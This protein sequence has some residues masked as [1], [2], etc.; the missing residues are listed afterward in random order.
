MR[1]S[2]GLLV[3]VASGAFAQR[4]TNSSTSALESSTTLPSN[5]DTTTGAAPSS[6]TSPAASQSVDLSDADL[7]QGTSLVTGANGQPAVRMAAGANGVAEF[8]SSP[9]ITELETGSQI[10][11]RFDISV[12][13]VVESRKRDF[14]GCTLD[15]KLDGE[16][17][18]S[19]PLADTN[20]ASVEQAS[21]PT[22]LN[23]DK[24]DIQFLQS[25]GSEPVQLDVSN[26]AVAAATD[27]G[28][29]GLPTGAATET[30]TETGTEVA[31]GTNS[32][33]ATTNSEGETVIPTGT[34]TG[35]AI[36]TGTN[37]EG[38]TTNSEGETVIPTGSET[39]I[40]TNSAGFTTNSE[41]ET[42]FPTGTQT[43]S[44]IAT[45]T[46][47][48]GATTNSEGETV[49]P[50]GTATGT[51]ASASASATSPAGFPGSVGVFTLFGCVGSSAGFPTFELAETN[52]QM[53]LERC[54]SLCTGRAYF[55]VYDT[56]CYCGDEIDADNTSRV[57]IDQCDIE[58]PGDKDNF[59]GGDGRLNRLRAR[60]AV[61]AGRLL[62]VY[63]SA[64]GAGATVTDSVTQ[65]VTDETTITTTF[66]TAITGAETTTT[67]TVTA[68]QI[69]VNGKCYSQGSDRTVF[70]F[71]EVNGSDCDNEW[72]Y[73][74]EECSCQGGKQYV[75]KFCSGG[76]CAG[77][78]VY[79]TQEC[80][81]WWNHETFFVAADC[82]CKEETVIYKPWENS[83]GTPNN[84]KA[85]LVPVCS[86]PK[87]PVVKV[88]THGGYTHPF[89][90]GTWTNG[91]AHCSGPHCP[92]PVP[93]CSG[94]KCP[95]PHCSGPHCPSPVPQCSG[96]KCPAPH[97]SGPHCPSPAPVCSGP[98]CPST[99]VVTLVP[100][101]SGA[102]C[103]AKPTGSQETGV[104]CNGADCHVATAT[105]SSPKPT[106][107]VPA[108]V[109][110]AGKQVVGA[111]TLFAA[112]FAALL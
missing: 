35:S 52:A 19:E 107:T 50:T 101:C 74:T 18:Y 40:E 10:Q 33:G 24:P 16:T 12:S 59:C 9:E 53:D 109:N 32:E 75:P 11:I 65:T 67:A 37:S 25:C 90:N 2:S 21:N 34:E 99:K 7:G 102:S 56:A 68:V 30:G 6:T 17:I 22:T 15:V 71:I 31:T 84:C 62:T 111:A 86:G 85:E 13:A 103:P 72:V 49:V 88:P 77:E 83:W 105:D 54:A 93:Q 64:I 29:T 36:A 94:P 38:A 3:A 82:G 14:E 57:D 112:L 55:G 61:P 41:G 45:G 48:E 1:L 87:C 42:V 79:K 91:T 28:S 98:S 44:A 100:Q 70:I 27:G 23:S 39:A 76:S 69:C 43:G 58:C 106:G 78:I 110:G 4:F 73:I 89:T 104:P 81:D 92:S 60:Q 47:S 66:T 63:A 8:T 20:G 108:I 95:A 5:I 51:E 46:N 26:L 96:P 97:C 80:H